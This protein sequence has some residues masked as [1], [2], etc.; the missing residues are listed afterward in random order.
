MVDDKF[1]AYKITNL[2]NGKNYIGIHKH[3]LKYGE[4]KRWKDHCKSKN[5]S[6]IARAIRKYGKEN[7]SF[8]HIAS[9]FNSQ[10]LLNLERFLIEQYNSIHP[11]GYN[12][13]V[14]GQGSLNP[15]LIVRN[16]IRQKMI[17]NKHSL[18][19]KRTQEE[20]RKSAEKRKGLKL[21]DEALNKMRL[22]KIGKPSPMKGLRHSEETK[23]KIRKSK[24]LY[25]E[26]YKN[27]YGKFISPTLGMK[28]NRPKGYHLSQEHRANLSKSS[29]KAWLLRK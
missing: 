13:N 22:A 3:G 4:I 19:Y 15:S 2:I 5:K 28:I 25:F 29:K 7:F 11:N 8:E 6:I 26:N 1:V 24:L 14:G 20:I 27:K 18:G 9:T 17:G 12:L 21:S 23:I 10:L 16:K